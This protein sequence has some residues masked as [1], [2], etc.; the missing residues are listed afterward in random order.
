MTAYVQGG[1]YLKHQNKRCL[2][3]QEGI[4]E[5]EKAE[6]RALH[7]FLQIAVHIVLLSE[8]EM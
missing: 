2:R 8:Y 5:K 3:W 7:I 1:F 4:N 6:E